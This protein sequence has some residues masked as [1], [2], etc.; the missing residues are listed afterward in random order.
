M[1]Q[2]SNIPGFACAQLDEQWNDTYMQLCSWVDERCATEQVTQ[3]LLPSRYSADP[4]EKKMGVWIMHQRAAAKHSKDRKLDAERRALLEAV[5][6]WTWAQEK[7]TPKQFSD[8][9]PNCKYTIAFDKADTKDLDHEHDDRTDGKCRNGG[10]VVVG[11]IQAHLRRN[12]WQ[13]TGSCGRTLSKNVFSAKMQNR[14]EGKVCKDCSN[15][16]KK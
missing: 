11:K 9:C 16:K 6:G 1:K 7:D 5:R 12:P 10:V 8:T 4:K 15:A 13:C 2:L 3:R 14:K